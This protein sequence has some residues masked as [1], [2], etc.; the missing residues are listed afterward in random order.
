MKNNPVSGVWDFWTN[1][2][3]TFFKV[4]FGLLGFSPLL[5]AWVSKMDTSGAIFGMTDFFHVHPSLVTLLCLHSYH[6]YTVTPDYTPNTTA[7][8]YT[9]WV[10]NTLHYANLNTSSMGKTHREPCN[11]R[12]SSMKYTASPVFSPVPTECYY[13]SSVSQR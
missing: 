8:S 12:H 3:K 13:Y 10:P 7:V 9:I 2:S 1:L 6:C 11:G 4:W 5:P